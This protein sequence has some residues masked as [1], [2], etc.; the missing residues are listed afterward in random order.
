MK[1]KRNENRIDYSVRKFGWTSEVEAQAGGCTYGLLAVAC[2]NRTRV[3]AYG[4][5]RCAMS[6]LV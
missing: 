6:Q 4:V 3:G 2:K 5:V 1:T